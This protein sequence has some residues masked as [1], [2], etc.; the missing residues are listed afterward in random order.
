M[1]AAVNPHPP[2][3]AEPPSAPRLSVV[4]VNYDA[5]DDCARLTSQLLDSIPKSNSAGE[6]EIILVDNASPGSGTPRWC[7][8]LAGLRFIARPSNSGFAAGV[9]TGWKCSQ[10]PWILVLNPDTVP[11]PEFLALVLARI[12][13]IESQGEL[14]SQRLGV[15]G[16]ALRNPDGSRQ[17]S[18]GGFPRLWRTL[19]GQLRA[20]SGR[21]YRSPARTVAGPVPWVTGAC[22]LLNARMLTELGGMDEEFFL[23]YEEVALCHSAWTRGWTVA[24]DPSIEVVHLRPLQNRAIPPKLRLITRHSK[25]LYFYKFNPRWESHALGWLIRLEALLR[26][27]WCA[28]NGRAIEARVWRAVGSLG[29]ASLGPDGPWPRGE[30]VRRL[31]EELVADTLASEPPP[32]AASRPGPN[33]S[34]STHRRRRHLVPGNNARSEQLNPID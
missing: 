30:A 22:A 17:P 14:H 7:G 19:W 18:V 34:E 24:Y 33:A 11:G 29:R 4:I 8:D 26:S 31:A 3:V 5:W 23:Y 15:I 1:V 21:K 2:G 12:D 32:A 13:E 16:F 9:N 10:A 28:C 6:V 20:R 27:I 25:L